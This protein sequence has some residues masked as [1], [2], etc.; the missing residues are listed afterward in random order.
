M[1]AKGCLHREGVRA[2]KCPAMIPNLNELPPFPE[3]PHPLKRLVRPMLGLLVGLFFVAGL[4][5]FYKVGL[6][7]MAD[8]EVNVIDGLRAVAHDLWMEGAARE[9]RRTDP[10]LVAEIVRLRGTVGLSPK[11]IA[12]PVEHQ[13][14][15]F[16]A[17]HQLLYLKGNQQVLQILVFLDETEGRVDILAFQTH[18]EFAGPTI[19]FRP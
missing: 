14:G 12:I 15:P 6:R 18:P 5:W 17:T 16:R 2:K 1:Q 13:T 4:T 11:I 8:Q 9:V 3:A 7:R 19:G 10:A